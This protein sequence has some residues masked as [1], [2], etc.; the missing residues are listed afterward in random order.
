[1]VSS[2]SQVMGRV[3]E[4]VS[5]TWRTATEMREVMGPLSDLGDKD[6]LN[7]GKVKR[8]VTK[9]TN[10]P[11]ITHG[12]SHL[13]GQVAV[14]Q[15]ADLVLWKPENLGSKPEM[16]L[17]PSV[18]VCAQMG[19]A[20]ASI[21]TVQP[22]RPQPM[23]GSYPASAALNSVAFVSGAVA[24]YDLAKRAEPVRGC[25]SVKKKDMMWNDDPKDESRCG[26]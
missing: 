11:T 21:P 1:M 4:V 7:N 25:R 13:V 18:I 14:G 8:C 15:L 10:N 12:I 2:D 16:V 26:E 24:S 9:Y 3:G 23:W 20:N 22:V 5:R 17:K 19:D 6:G